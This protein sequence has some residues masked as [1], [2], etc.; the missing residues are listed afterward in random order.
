MA[1]S[2]PPL[3]AIR[4]FEAAARHLSFS[5]A[6]EELHVTPAAISQQI[7]SLEQ[8]L[9]APLFHRLNRALTLTEAGS[10]LLP[11]A[12]DGLD[13]LAVSWRRV[14]QQE[15]GSLDVNTSPGFAAKWLIP[16]LDRFH[17]IHPDI[18]VRITASME[19]VD[20]DRDEV[21]VGIRFGAGGY[22][23][24]EEELL[25]AEEV[26]PVCS[27]K[28]LEGEHPLR[29]PE[30]LKYH[31]FLHDGSHLP[32]VMKPD[33]HMWLAAMGIEGI[34]PNYGMTFTPWTMVMQ[35]AIEGQG[36]ALGR[37][38]LCAADLEA[39]RLVNPFDLSLPISFAH[40][41]VYLP[42]A[43]SRPKVKAF[44]DWIMDETAEMREALSSLAP[45]RAAV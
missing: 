16:R 8:H 30:D 24:L 45:A 32:G 34:E 27:P 29:T 21:D 13:I 37:R 40:R 3:N 15:A 11:G 36:V 20:F 22:E 19:L 23:G 44:R 35:A 17:T 1:R 18:E 5:K 42:G 12:S 28:L 6:A 25:M 4:A 10:S 31:Q 2:L 41:L 9:G 33:W 43:L 39:G 38:T 7:K 26:I 14:R